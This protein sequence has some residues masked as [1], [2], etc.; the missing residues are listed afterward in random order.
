MNVWG[1]RAC[2]L[3]DIIRYMIFLNFDIEL[4]QKNCYEV[5]QTYKMN[6]KMAYRVFRETEDEFS[7]RNYVRIDT[8]ESVDKQAHWFNIS[9]Y[10]KLENLKNSIEA[11]SRLSEVFKQ[12]VGY[13]T[14]KEGFELCLTSKY[15]MEK[16]K[17]PVLENVLRNYE[18]RQQDR[19]LIWLSYLPSVNLIYLEKDTNLTYFQSYQKKK[20]RKQLDV[21]PDLEIIDLDLS[22]ST[23][24]FDEK[25]YDVPILNFFVKNCLF[26]I[27][28]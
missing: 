23:R 14:P 21:Y 5:S 22:R 7:I 26:P 2:S 11:Q 12:L 10:P 19:V 8:N 20:M 3:N 13:L 16:V 27:R 18:L 4:I 9:M 24:F 17:R 6:K 1:I 28:L 25:N 15:N